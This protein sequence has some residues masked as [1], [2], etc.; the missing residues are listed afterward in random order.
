MA[1]AGQDVCFYRRKMIK[2]VIFLLRI[3][4][5]PKDDG[6]FEKG[7]LPLLE[8][9]GLENAAAK[10]VVER[11]R[12]IADVHT[13]SMR[14]A[15][16]LVVNVKVSGS[17]TAQM[18][19]AG[20]KA[21]KTIDL[22]TMRAP[23]TTVASLLEF[24]IST[25]KNKEKFRMPIHSQSQGEEGMLLNDSK[26]TRTPLQV[27]LDDIEAWEESCSAQSST[28]EAADG[29]GAASAP[30]EAAAEGPGAADGGKDTAGAAIMRLMRAGDD[31][32]QSAGDGAPKAEQAADRMAELRSFLDY[33][34]EVRAACGPRLGVLAI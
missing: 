25:S 32:E 9:H 26:E 13:L 22:V 21:L 23:K 16:K 11:V 33:I 8:G 6:S 14:E 27:L 10:R 30:A 24:A 15:A 34:S 1:C 2:S 17:L 3:V 5:N 28:T 4:A 18:L 20:K 19:S 12:K 7:F 29:D 31:Q